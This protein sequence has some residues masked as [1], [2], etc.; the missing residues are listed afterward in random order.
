[1][2]GTFRDAFKIPELKNRI[3][4]TLMIIAVYRIGCHIPTPGINGRVL[5]E[6][7]SQRAGVLAFAD[8]FTG[9]ALSRA[10]VLA[11]GIMPYITASII[12]Q[13]LTPVVPYLEKLA[14]EGEEGRKKI[15][16]YTRYGTIVIS[17][18]QS[19]SFAIIL[20]RMQGTREPIVMNPGL[21]FKLLTMLTFTTGAGFVMWLGE[22]ISDRGIGNG[23]SLIIYTS[24]ISRMPMAFG[25]AIRYL[26][27][28]DMTPFVAILLVAVMVIVV[29]GVIVLTQ[30]QRRIP[31]QYPRQVKG[32]RVYGGQKSYLPLRVNQAGVIPIIF[33]SAMLMFPGM[34]SSVIRNTTVQTFLLTWGN[35]D[36]LAYNAA[37]AL[38]I[39]LFCYFY[40][41]I[42]F[43]PV[44]IADNMKRFGGFVPGVRP[45]KATAEYLD[46]IM[47]RV[48]F[49]GAFALAAVATFPV[50]VQRG[51]TVDREIANF[52][53][54]TGLLILVGVALDTVS[55]MESHLLMRHYD[56]FMKKGRIRGRR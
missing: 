23:M 42:T 12:F 39:I 35:Q 34:L 22:Q 40:T 26:R 20:E 27:Q 56:G 38:L 31:V 18:I 7:F 25:T 16:Q 51:F 9:G 10:T 32:R 30:A 11:L 37:F 36:S 5:S 3:L 44:D 17:M 45:G 24:I 55:Q 46:Y 28:G 2:L 13:L 15:T 4:F 49:A 43:N 47:T 50:F 8:L 19:L 41:A 33:A 29:A 52:F 14:K 21:A 53:G 1:V 54:G 6:I 48:T